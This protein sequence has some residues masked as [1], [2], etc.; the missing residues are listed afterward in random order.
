MGAL[1]GIPLSQLPDP[2]G[3]ITPFLGTVLFAWLGVSIM[4]ARADDISALLFTV[5]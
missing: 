5:P 3:A 4:M 1:L 2:L